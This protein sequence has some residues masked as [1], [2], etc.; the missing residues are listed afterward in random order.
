MDQGLGRA[1]SHAGR[2]LKVRAPVAAIG[3]GNVWITA[4]DLVGADHDA[5]PAANAF[6]CLGENNALV[7]AGDGPA[8]AGMDTGG[9][10]AV[11]AEDGNLGVVRQPFHIDPGP[12][13]HGLV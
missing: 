4:D 11:A 13:L 3:F 1:G 9:I 6:V 5:G 2:N 7:R 8:D 12:G 10:F